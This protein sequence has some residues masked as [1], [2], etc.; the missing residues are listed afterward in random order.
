M[1]T[2]GGAWYSFEVRSL[3][4]SGCG[5]DAQP[6]GLGG[7]TPCTR[8]SPGMMLYCMRILNTCVYD[9]I[10]LY[11]CLA[12]FTQVAVMLLA[13]NFREDAFKRRRDVM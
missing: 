4:G 5:S 7:Y 13:I 8:I 12:L 1:S 10:L 6:K 2:L 9:T 11:V 3:L